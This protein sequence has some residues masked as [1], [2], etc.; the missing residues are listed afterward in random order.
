MLSP[1]PSFKIKNDEKELNNTIKFNILLENLKH[2]CPIKR[3]IHGNG[4]IDHRVTNARWV[5]GPIFCS[6]PDIVM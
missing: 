4:K 5:M 1:A 2:S 3:L 6:K